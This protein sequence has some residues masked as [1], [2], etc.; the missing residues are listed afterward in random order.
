MGDTRSMAYDYNGNLTSETDFR[1]NQ[2]THQY[3]S[4][5][6][7]TRTNAPLGKV[8]LYS[9]HDALGNVLAESTSGPDG[10]TRR[11]QYEYRHPQNLRTHVRQA[12][13]STTWTETVTAYDGNGNVVAVM[14]PNGNLETRS[15][16]D[17]DR[18]IHVESPEDR[19][20]ELAYDQADRKNSETLS[21]PGLDDPQVRTWTY[22]GRGRETT[23]IDAQGK[24]WRTGYDAADRPISRSNPLGATWRSTYDPR[25]RIVQE[26]G[27]V[28]EQINI[29]GYD[30]AAIVRWRKRPTVACSNTRM[31]S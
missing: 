4:A 24:V 8:T 16:D 1:G 18:L 27:P 14:D 30:A 7:R 13:D 19:V 6:R 3:D 29:Y 22:D 25:G 28:E 21:G 12:I 5:N 17:R 31:T 23:R 2:T 15:Y 26:T 11:T 20:V 10:S 9:D